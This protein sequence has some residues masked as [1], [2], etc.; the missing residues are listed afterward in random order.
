[1]KQFILCAHI[2][3]ILGSSLFGT[4]VDMFCDQFDK[5]FYNN[6]L[7]LEKMG[8]TVLKKRDLPIK[9]KVK[10]CIRLASLYTYTG[11]YEEAK[12][13]ASIGKSL[14]KDSSLPKLLARSLSILS[15]A[16]LGLAEQ[17]TNDAQSLLLF[18][19]AKDLGEEALALAREIKNHTFLLAKVLCNLGS[20]YAQS[21]YERSS[22]AIDLYK[23]ALSNLE[24][25]DIE[26]YKTLNKLAQA[27]LQM[28]QL[29]QAWE[30][31]TP[32]LHLQLEEG[33]RAFIYITAMKISLKEGGVLQASI[34]ANNAMRILKNYTYHLIQNLWKQRYNILIK[35]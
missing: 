26:T 14:A 3:I 17:Q 20:V 5:G 31:L 10:V 1:M 13:Y 7:D 23:E 30:T 27:Q 35:R 19:Q 18:N 22:I 25:D 11:K 8:K 33:V 29:K 12:K 16:Y 28:N 34:F 15:K 6:L 21:P 32:L 4:T 9:G 2:F 24:E